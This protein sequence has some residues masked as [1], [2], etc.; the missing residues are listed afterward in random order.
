M[1]L[2]MLCLYTYIYNYSV[3]LRHPVL[4][5]L[6]V[7]GLPTPAT[8]CLFLYAAVVSH[9]TMTHSEFLFRYLSRKVAISA[10]A[11]RIT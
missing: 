7:T 8:E 2:A 11:N 4:L 9:Q 1:P 6:I 5:L 3:L 10:M